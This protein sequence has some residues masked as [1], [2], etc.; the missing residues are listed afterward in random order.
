MKIKVKKANISSEFII[1]KYLPANYS[2]TFE[3]IAPLPDE[4]TPDDLLIAFWGMDKGWVDS[5][6]KL[7]NALVKPLGLKSGDKDRGLG[8]AECIRKGGSYSFASVTDKSANETVISLN[9]KHL[10][11]YLSANIS[12]AENNRKR[13]SLI[14]VVHFH[15]WLGYVYFYAIMPFHGLVVKEVLK[16]SVK[17]LSDS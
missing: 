17:K 8:M 2:D 5:L 3:C 12:E 1:N 11:A 16:E 7:R 14:T 15:N 6:F 9:D 13:I 10:K 4:V